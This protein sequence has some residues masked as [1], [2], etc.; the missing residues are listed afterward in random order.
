MGKTFPLPYLY[1]PNEKECETRSPTLWN[2]TGRTCVIVREGLRPQ[3]LNT[4]TFII[5]Q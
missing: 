1:S 5:T 2:M 4:L 3:Q